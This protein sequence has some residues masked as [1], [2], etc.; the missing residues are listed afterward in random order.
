MK[1]YLGWAVALG[2]VMAG[3]VWAEEASAA[4]PAESK[5]VVAAPATE[6][7]AGG[8]EVVEAAIATVVENRQPVGG[9]E[10]FNAQVGKLFCW[11]KIAGGE[12][13]GEIV[14]EWRKGNE[15]VASVTLAIGGSPWRVYSSKIILPE[16][17][18]KW[19]VAIKQG[20]RVLKTLEFTVE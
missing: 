9:A 17:T 19:S 4:E 6:T 1:K 7:T 3:Q 15:V 5:A 10:T 18:G 20:D 8:W 2:I 14:H 11:S 13:G 16:M 12:A